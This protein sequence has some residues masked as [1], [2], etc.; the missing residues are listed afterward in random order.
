MEVCFFRW[1]RRIYS[2]DSWK[3]LN[4]IE[5]NMWL[6]LKKI[7][8]FGTSVVIS[9]DGPEEITDA[10]G[11]PKCFPFEYDRIYKFLVSSWHGCYLS[12][13]PEKTLAVLKIP[14][15]LRWSFGMTS[16]TLENNFRIRLRCVVHSEEKISSK[17][18]I[19]KYYTLLET[20]TKLNFL[21]V[22]A[23]LRISSRKFSDDLFTSPIESLLSIKICH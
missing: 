6:E 12:G 19:L 7:F 2:R 9:S 18:A 1:N 21:R 17:M 11:F 13:N 23:V 10:F 22:C 5:A 8:Q 20:K 4:H 14:Y 15:A 3:F 16:Q